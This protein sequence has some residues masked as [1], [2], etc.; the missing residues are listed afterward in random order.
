MVE[1]INRD[2]WER[3][4]KKKRKD[5]PR[6]KYTATAG[7]INVSFVTVERKKKGQ[8]NSDGGGQRAVWER[9]NNRN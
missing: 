9:E 3:K 1:R 6:G 7:G 2:I 4:E 5:E 8:E